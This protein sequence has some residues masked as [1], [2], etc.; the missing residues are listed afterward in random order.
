MAD[1]TDLD[2][3]R[4]RVLDALQSRSPR[5]AGVYRTGLEALRSTPSEGCESARVSVACHCMREL[6]NGLPA[7]LGDTVVPRPEPPSSALMAKLP[8]M[9]ARH[10]DVDLAAEQDSIPV[11]RAVAHALGA[12]IGAAAQERGRNRANAAAL[13][14][15]GTDARHP[16]IQQWMDAYQFFLGWTHLDRNHETRPLPQDGDLLAAIRVVE[17]VIEVRTA[18]FFDNLHSIE[19]L[20]AEINA[21]IEEEK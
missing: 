18:V 2:E 15:G 7:V 20:L 19:A 16:A 5:L 4:L 10:P 3:R 11:P 21:P 12:L 6:M 9:L 1:V 13:V 17:D 14:T 8:E